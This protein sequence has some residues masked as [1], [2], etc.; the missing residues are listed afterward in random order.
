VCTEGNQVFSFGCNEYGELGLGHEQPMVVPSQVAIQE[1]SG[2]Y[3]IACGRNHS[4]AVDVDGHLYMWGWGGRG[5]LGQ[6]EI[7]KSPQS[8]PVLVE[9]FND[10]PVT[11]ISC[12][13]GHSCCL[14]GGGIPYCWG[15]N[16]AGQLGVPLST[17]EVCRPRAVLIPTG[18]H[19]TQ[20]ACGANFTVALSSTGSVFTWGLGASGQL[21]HG[22]NKSR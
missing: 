19:I 4:A 6:G 14:S 15:D 20:V 21:A 13:D 11:D 8:S 3:R 2:V 5:Q 9:G 22:E 1:G 17:Q 12:G 7:S 10:Q 16:S 18:N